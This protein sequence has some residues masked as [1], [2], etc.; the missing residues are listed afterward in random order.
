MRRKPASSRR[1]SH[2]KER[3]SWPMFTKESQLSH[4]RAAEMGRRSPKVRAREERRPSMAMRR[5]EVSE[6]PKG[7]VREG[8]ARKAELELTTSVTRGSRSCAGRMPSVPMRPGICR[9][10]ERK[11]KK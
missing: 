4:E 11:A 2:W 6:A 1:V 10:R 9:N 5:R 7:H 3:K 8:S